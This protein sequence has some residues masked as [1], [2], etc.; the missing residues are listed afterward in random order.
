M[1]CCDD[2]ILRVVYDH[3]LLCSLAW[4]MQNIIIV[5]RGRAVE[6]RRRLRYTTNTMRYCVSPSI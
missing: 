6:T 2:A 1:S 4:G 5:E 3:V